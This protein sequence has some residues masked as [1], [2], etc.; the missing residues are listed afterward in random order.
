MSLLVESEKAITLDTNAAFKSVWVTNSLDGSEDFLVSDKILGLVRDSMRQFRNKMTA[1]PP[2]TVKE[3][4][5]SL[6]PWK[7]IK[8]GKNIEGSELFD[9]KEIKEE[10]EDEHGDEEEINANQLLQALTGNIPVQLATQKETQERNVVT[11]NSVSLVRITES[12]QI[13]KDAKLLDKIKKFLTNM[14]HL[15]SL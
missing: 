12:N 5:C 3:V 15:L 9:G 10:E 8:R 1:T 14:R 4:I 13:N 6:I 11:G 2:K 7:G